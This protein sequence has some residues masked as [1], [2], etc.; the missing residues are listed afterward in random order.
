MPS[1]TTSVDFTYLPPHEVP[2]L[3]ACGL[4]L[5]LLFGSLVAPSIR[6]KRRT[7][8]LATSSGMQGQSE[9]D[10]A[11]PSSAIAVRDSRS[12]P[13][14]SF[15]EPKRG[16]CKGT[17]EQ[18]PSGAR[19]L[20]TDTR[21]FLGARTYRMHSVLKPPDETLTQRHTAPPRRTLSHLT[22]TFRGH[23]GE[24]ATPSTPTRHQHRRDH[25]G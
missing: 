24:R 20:G 22:P 15:F 1:G 3:V 21:Q 19:D 13:D 18:T 7:P 16:G 6:R 9:A 17:V 11:F 10:G 4:A 14:R 12:R 5:L 23:S 8:P 2:A 25:G